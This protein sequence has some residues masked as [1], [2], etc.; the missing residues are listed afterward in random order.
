MNFTFECGI[1]EKHSVAGFRIQIYKVFIDK[2]LTHE[3]EGR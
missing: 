3:C 2:R 1:K